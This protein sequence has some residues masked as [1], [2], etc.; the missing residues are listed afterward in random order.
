[1]SD[2]KSVIAFIAGTGLGGAG[3]WFLLKK[4]YERRFDEELISVKESFHI[5]KE[6]LDEEIEK[7]KKESEPEKEKT[8]KNDISDNSE[9]KPENTSK[10]KYVKYITDKNVDNDISN[11]KNIPYTISPDDFGEKG[12]AE[13]TLTYYL[14][15]ILA[16]DTGYIID[17]VEGM[18]GDALSHFGEYEKDAIHC[19][20]DA[21]RCDYEILKD[22][23]RYA[24]VRRSFPRNM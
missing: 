24:D 1:M 2:F 23:R 6:Q 8:E 9:K 17:D 12:Y 14:D 20:N 13:T 3:A 11:V 10:G 7:L 19:R 4:I 16:D 21:K 22:L 15:G 18:I 5:R